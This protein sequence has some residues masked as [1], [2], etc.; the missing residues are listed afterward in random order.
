MVPQKSHQKETENRSL[1]PASF[2]V[3]FQY[4]Q[5]LFQVFSKDLLNLLEIVLLVQPVK[6][7]S[8]FCFAMP[9]DK[10]SH[11]FYG[12][13]IFLRIE[14]LPAAGQFLT[15]PASVQ[16]FLPAAGSVRAYAV[17]R[18]GRVGAGVICRPASSAPV[19]QKTVIAGQAAVSNGI[20]TF[21]GLLAQLVFD[22]AHCL[23]MHDPVP[24]EGHLNQPANIFAAPVIDQPEGILVIAYTTASDQPFPIRVGELPLQILVFQF[25]QQSV[26][27]F[28]NSPAVFKYRFHIK[29][30]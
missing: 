1:C 7:R 22:A 27:R 26:C 5:T 25:S 11:G 21:S 29:L 8:Q 24:A 28:H 4:F 23:N 15:S 20:H 10:Q 17:R 13:Y 14:S 30:L 2:P 16:A 12:V 9:P 3:L 6:N 19:L 18:T